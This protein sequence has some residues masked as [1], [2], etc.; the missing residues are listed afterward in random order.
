MSRGWTADTAVAGVTSVQAGLGSSRCHV[1]V[2][3]CHAGHLICIGHHLC[4]DNATRSLA[5]YG[6]QADCSSTGLGDQVISDQETAP[7]ITRV[8]LKMVLVV[9]VYGAGDQ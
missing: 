2:T 9:V 7:V 3:R 6:H 1:A 5:L 8:G 4:Y